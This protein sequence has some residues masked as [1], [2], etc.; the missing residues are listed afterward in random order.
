MIKGAN[1]QF[2]AS[3]RGGPAMASFQKG[4]KGVKKAQDNVTKSSGSFFKGMNAN[5][6][7]IQQVGFQ[8]SDLGVQIAGGQSALLALTQNVPQVVQMFGAWGGI[9]AGLITLLGTFAI[10]LI[11]SGKGFADIAPALGITRDELSQLGI[12]LTK[13]KNQM[14]DFANVVINH[15]DVLL[16][17]LTLYASFLT[18]RFITASI[19]SGKATIFFGKSL[20]FLRKALIRTGIGAL[21]V[22]AGYLIERLFT[23]RKA[24]GSWAETFKVSGE[25]IRQVIVQ[26]PTYLL[27]LQMKWTAMNLDMTAS[28]Q[29]FLAKTAGGMPDWVNNLVSTMIS[30]G[31]SMGAVWEGLKGTIFNIMVSVV[32]NVTDKMRTAINNIIGIA[33]K[34]PGINIKLIPD[35]FGN[36]KAEAQ[37]TL[38]G[39]NAKIKQIFDDNAGKKFFGADG[40][41]TKKLFGDAAETSKAADAFRK[42]GDTILKGANDAIPAWTKLKELLKSGDAD[43]FD[44]RNLFGGKKDDATGGGDDPVTA[45]I[46][47]TNK[48]LK[49]NP[50]KVVANTVDVKTKLTELQELTKKI[51]T[52]ISQSFSNNFKGLLKG[53]TSFRDAMLGV[54][55]TILDKMLDLLLNPVFDAIGGAISGGLTSAFGSLASFDGGGRTSPGARVGGMDGKGGKLAMLHPNETVLDHTKGQQASSSSTVNMNIYGVTDADSFKRSKKQI[56]RDIRMAMR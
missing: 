12:V 15:I 26:I 13:I 35:D 1:F 30:T 49:D 4:L 47:S 45:K 21:I 28:F 41:I 38:N 51:G 50:I 5:R 7:I 43:D 24:T 37:D 29:L 6:R 19:A 31:Q 39:V 48:K 56:T 22:A 32:N 40:S 11:K 36:I 9:L 10:L 33:N 16:I 2:S 54:L 14:I 27:A 3:N 17:S 23:L 44:V 34:I 20:V 55:D 52:S 42:I 46:K 25:L 18:G 53:T 8:V